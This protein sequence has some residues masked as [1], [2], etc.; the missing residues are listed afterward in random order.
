MSS[1]KKLPYDPIVRYERRLENVICEPITEFDGKLAA[2][3]EKMF[4]TMYAY[5]GVGLAAPQLGNFVC[6]NVIDFPQHDFRRV[7]IN[8]EILEEKGETVEREGCLSIPGKNVQAP[9][10][11]NKTI[12]YTYQD[13]N[14]T[15]HEE[16]IDGWKA[17]CVQHE[18]D[19]LKGIFFIN[20]VSPLWKDLVLNRYQNFCKGMK[21]VDN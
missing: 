8:P 1:D 13:V 19:H 6:L 21:E 10:R 9:V 4:D 11:R 3:V 17:R 5:H 16:T 18:V 7:L 12:T 20:R 2:T 14:G 15:R